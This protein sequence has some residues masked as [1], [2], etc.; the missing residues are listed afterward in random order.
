MIFDNDYSGDSNVPSLCW[1][2]DVQSTLNLWSRISPNGL[3][4]NG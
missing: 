2:V 3:A 1:F 4:N